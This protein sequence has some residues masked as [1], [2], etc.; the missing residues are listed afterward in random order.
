MAVAIALPVA[1]YLAAVRLT[2]F[3]LG[4]KTPFRSLFA[5]FTFAT[6]PLAFAYHIAHNLAHLLREGIGAGAVF[7]NPLGVGALPLSIEQRHARMSEMALAPTTL[8]A[9][10]ALLI[11][12][13]F[14]V[15]VM[16]IRRRSADLINK[17]SGTARLSGTAKT[18]GGKS[19]ALWPV[20]P[21]FIFAALMT[22][23]HLWLLM[24]PM[25][26]RG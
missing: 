24:Q 26:M 3:F 25:I 23:Y 13:G 20:A 4:D 8:A 11:A 21:L 22:G 16:V 12:L 10:Q 7:A 19:G 2:G 9:I 18:A 17:A 1:L 14:L 15:A 5:S 6:L